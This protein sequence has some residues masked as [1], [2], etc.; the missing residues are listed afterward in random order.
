MF[1]GLENVVLVPVKANIGADTFRGNVMPIV[2]LSRQRN[3][4]KGNQ[5]NNTR[6]DASVGLKANL[7][8][9]KINGFGYFS[10]ERMSQFLFSSVMQTS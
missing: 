3:S 1:W 6:E 4:P 5:M 9:W 2:N 7:P 8:S 10:L